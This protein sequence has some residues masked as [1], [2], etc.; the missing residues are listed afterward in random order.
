MKTVHESDLSRLRQI[1]TLTQLQ[2][3]WRECIS[4][5]VPHDCALLG[6][7]ELT[8]GRF[9]IRGIVMQHGELRGKPDELSA[10]CSRLLMV[11]NLMEE[12]CEIDLG[13]C[14]CVGRPPSPGQVAGSRRFLVHG[15]HRGSLVDFVLLSS[16]EWEDTHAPRELLGRIIKPI[17]DA[18]GRIPKRQNMPL[19]ATAHRPNSPARLTPREGQIVDAVAEGLT[20]KEIARRLGIS[21]NTVRNQMATLSTKLGVHSRTQ[22]AVKTAA[23][24]HNERD[25]R[26]AVSV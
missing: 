18:C 8:N 24:L 10:K 5:L 17:S 14:D 25:N 7:A 22:I 9:G 23:M 15:A 26:A 21:P 19:G 3:W 16:R 4:G 6:E 13:N 20:N 1:T 12:P 2:V 11:W